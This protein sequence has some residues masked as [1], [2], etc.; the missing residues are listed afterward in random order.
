[1]PHKRYLG[2]PLLLRTCPAPGR[3]PFVHPATSLS[4]APP[5]PSPPSAPTPPQAIK[6]FEELALS[7]DLRLDWVLRPGD[8]QLLSNHVAL[9]SRQGFMDDPQAR[10]VAG[11][12]GRS[13]GGARGLPQQPVMRVMRLPLGERPPAPHCRAHPPPPPTAA[14]TPPASSPHAG[15]LEAASPAAPVVVAARGAAAARGVPRDPGR[16]AGGG[17]ARRHRA[18]AAAVRAGGAHGVSRA[19]RPPA[20]LAGA[21]GGAAH[22][23]AAPGAHNQEFCTAT[24]LLV[25]LLMYSMRPSIPHANQPQ[26]DLYM[27]PLRVRHCKSESCPSHP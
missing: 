2:H 4:P 14:L 9:H 11:E 16:V 24:F 15:P 7:D 17:Q 6:V 21:A 3:L 10:R 18:G 1:M 22:C 12:G 25:Q 26:R 13:A 19:R 5:P 23:G 20:S 27:S 8:V